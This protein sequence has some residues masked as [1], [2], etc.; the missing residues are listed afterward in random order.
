M[1]QINEKM[2]RHLTEGFMSI[3]QT[4]GHTLLR[5]FELGQKPGYVERYDPVTFTRE[6]TPRRDILG[7]VIR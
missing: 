3:A 7:R 1:E 2:G 5:V 4:V 6:W